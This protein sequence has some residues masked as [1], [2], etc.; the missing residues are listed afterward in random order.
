MM[1]GPKE[2]SNDLPPLGAPVRAPAPPP[3]PDERVAPGILRTP[4][5]RF[6]T[7]LP[8]FSGFDPKFCPGSNPENPQTED[9]EDLPDG[10]TRDAGGTLRF[11]C[12]SCGCRDAEWCGTPAEFETD[13]LY[14][15]V[16]GGSPMCLP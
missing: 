11:T 9:D 12:R 16:C 2:P 1:P 3:K 6:K 10:L 14:Y 15:R 4:D 5:G 13:D 8:S 7:D